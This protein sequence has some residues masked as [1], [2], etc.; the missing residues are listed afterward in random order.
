MHILDSVVTQKCFENLELL[1]LNFEID[2][3]Q[4]LIPNVCATSSF[5]K[6]VGFRLSNKWIQKLMLLFREMIISKL[7]R[8]AILDYPRMAILWRMKGNPFHRIVLK[9]D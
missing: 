3:H 4:K 7:T 8:I 5:L 2:F 9:Y 1:S 6:L